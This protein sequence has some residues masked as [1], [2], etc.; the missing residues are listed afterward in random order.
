MYCDKKGESMDKKST[1]REVLANKLTTKRF[2]S[3]MFD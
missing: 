3:D 2:H 1:R